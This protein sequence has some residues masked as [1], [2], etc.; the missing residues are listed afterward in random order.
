M[1]ERLTK[2]RALMLE[3]KIDCYVLPHGDNH[4][5][6]YLAP[7]DERIKFISGFS[8]S[9]GIC[10]VTQ[11]EARMWTDGRY[12]LAAGKQLFEGWTMMKME[13]D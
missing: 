2:L 11:K 6:E 4:N 13:A 9:N 1:S 12:Y 5:S 10:V 8:G 3:Q 7:C